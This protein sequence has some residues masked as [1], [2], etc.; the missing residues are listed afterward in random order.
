LAFGCFFFDGMQATLYKMAQRV[1]LENEHVSS[2]TYTLPNRHYIPVDMAYMGIDNISPLSGFFVSLN[3]VWI[4]FD[5]GSLSL[6]IGVGASCMFLMVE[7]LV[8][9]GWSFDV[10]VPV[11][12]RR[13]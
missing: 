1:I 5:P 12:Q 7:V 3:C 4:R 11:T 8:F 13:G 2:V 6:P 10:H 9:D